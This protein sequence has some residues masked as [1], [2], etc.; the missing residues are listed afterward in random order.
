MIEINGIKFNYPIMKNHEEDIFIEAFKEDPYRIKYVE[1]GELVIDIGAYIGTFSLRCAIEKHCTVYSYEPSSINYS[2]LIENIK[3]NNME[4]KIKAFKIAI[5]NKNGIRKFYY[6]PHHPGGSSFYKGEN[7]TEEEMVQCITLKNVFESNDILC[8][9]TLKIDC[10]SAEQE[11]F[12]EESIPYFKKTKYIVLEWHYYDG[13]IYADYL[14][15]INFSVLI[16]GTGVPPTPYDIT[17]ARGV[18]YAWNNKL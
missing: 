6:K 2:Y 7:I 9:D 16:T 13:N 8:C 18:L 14:R 1:N 11:I 5:G 3:L 4:H 17:L 12:N 15:D 10:E